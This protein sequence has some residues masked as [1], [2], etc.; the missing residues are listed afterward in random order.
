MLPSQ[1]ILAQWT[2]FVVQIG[3]LLGLWIYVWKTWHIAESTQVAA[4]SSAKSVEE[5]Q[6]SREQ[7]LEPR[8]VVYFSSASS[9]LAEIVIENFGGGAAAEVQCLSLIHI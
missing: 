6:R 9:T 2:L 7:Q 8:V 3:G 5:M 4:E 1:S